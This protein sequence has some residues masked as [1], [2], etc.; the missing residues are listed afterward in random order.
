MSTPALS[1]VELP[2]CGELVDDVAGR[3]ADNPKSP[4]GKNLSRGNRL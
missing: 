3:L 2:D 1:G 4:S